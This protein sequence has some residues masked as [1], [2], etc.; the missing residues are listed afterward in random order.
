VTSAAKAVDEK[1]GPYRIVR[2]SFSGWEKSEQKSLRVASRRVAGCGEK[3]SD[4]TR[5]ED[6]GQYQKNCATVEFFFET[7]VGHI[8][9]KIRLKT[10]ASS[11]RK[12]EVGR[13]AGNHAEV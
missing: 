9:V 5:L 4:C 1:Q 7:L 10:T 13:S 3:R 6:V 2:S 12:A 11:A 8:E